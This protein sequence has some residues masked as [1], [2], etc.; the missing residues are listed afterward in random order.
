MFLDCPALAEV[1][2]C[3]YAGLFT[4]QFCRGGAECAQ[5]SGNLRLELLVPA[6]WNR[7]KFMTRRAVCLVRL[8]DKC[9]IVLGNDLHKVKCLVE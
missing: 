3:G 1:R 4:P 8:G 2:P 5:N 9:C 6:G 7:E